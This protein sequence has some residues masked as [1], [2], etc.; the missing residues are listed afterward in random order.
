MRLW[1]GG[2][3]DSMRARNVLSLALAS[4]AVAAAAAQ[5]A[6][7]RAAVP[8]QLQANEEQV[9]PPALVN[10]LA[11]WLAG[12][13][14]FEMRKASSTAT[15]LKAAAQVIAPILDASLMATVIQR[16]QQL[17]PLPKGNT[18]QIVARTLRVA[19]TLRPLLY[20]DL[21]ETLGVAKAVALASLDARGVAGTFCVTLP[22][23]GTQRR[24]QAQQW[25]LTVKLTAY[26]P[27]GEA[28][29]TAALDASL[30]VI[31]PVVVEVPLL[32]K[33]PHAKHLVGRAGKHVRSLLLS[34]EVA[35]Q[36]A[37]ADLTDQVQWSTRLGLDIGPRQNP[38]HVRVTALALP[39]LP[40]T[41]GLSLGAP[42]LLAQATARMVPGF[43]SCVQAWLDQRVVCHHEAMQDATCRQ[44]LAEAPPERWIVEAPLVVKERV[45]AKRERDA[46][47]TQRH[48]RRKLA[49]AQRVAT[50][51]RGLRRGQDHTAKHSAKRPMASRLAPRLRESSAHAW[52]WAM[53]PR[54][55]QEWA[56]EEIEHYTMVCV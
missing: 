1:E 37:C 56:R 31:S 25:E 52:L 21:G 46:R 43:R 54:P 40:H 8:A 6:T 27:C 39:A 24:D 28:A 44:L 53:C 32:D 20:R 38:S 13:G 55:S 4:H 35:I 41:G 33:H 47:C 19:P 30:A 51:T 2:E 48:S 5:D 11:K 26:H 12:A 42:G 14:R 29:A 49:K 45:E 17:G 10:R 34:L 22:E 50:A 18:A 3:I 9:V 36:G 15:A 16:A 7:A 23:F